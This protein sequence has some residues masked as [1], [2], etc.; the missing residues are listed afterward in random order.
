MTS[1][2]ITGNLSRSFD[3]FKTQWN[4]LRVFCCS[5]W[6]RCEYDL[7]SLTS[8]W[9]SSKSKLLCVSFL[10]SLMRVSKKTKLINPPTNCRSHKA[11]LKYSFAVLLAAVPK[12]LYSYGSFDLNNDNL[13]STTKLVQTL[14]LQHLLVSHFADSTLRKKEK[15]AFPSLT[16]PRKQ[17]CVLVVTR[18]TLI[19]KTTT[20]INIGWEGVQI[21]SLP[22]FYFV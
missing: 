12:L 4:E 21:A 17:Y 1:K 11:I 2:I 15:Q 8:Y 16:H 22:L 18:V 5:H 10:D 19:Y 14:Y 7:S 20:K 13:Q 9:I 6:H 3:W